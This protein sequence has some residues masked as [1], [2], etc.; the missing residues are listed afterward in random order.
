MGVVVWC[1]V[2]RNQRGYSTHLV[3]MVVEV[4]EEE[5]ATKEEKMEAVEVEDQFVALH[6]RASMDIWA[7]PG[8]RHRLRSV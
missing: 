6:N 5:V 7:Q 1:P 4:V 3:Q 8:F 2:L